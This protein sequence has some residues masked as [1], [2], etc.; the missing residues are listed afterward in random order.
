MGI[1]DRTLL[2]GKNFVQEAQTIAT[3]LDDHRHV[4]IMSVIA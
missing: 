2:Q 4:Y 3:I 1:L